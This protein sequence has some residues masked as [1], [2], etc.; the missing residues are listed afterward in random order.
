VLTN[1]RVRQGRELIC[2]ARSRHFLDEIREMVSKHSPAFTRWDASSGSRLGTRMAA[3]W[4]AVS[5]EEGPDSGE[6]SG[7]EEEGPGSG[8]GEDE[9]A[10]SLGGGRAAAA[11]P[12]PPAMVPLR[13]R[14]AALRRTLLLLLPALPSS[15]RRRSPFFLRPLGFPN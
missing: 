5:E 3:P 12:V 8:E 2:Q 13:R 7:S 6:A 11:E 4:P 15:P 1:Q 9:H 10:D 14:G